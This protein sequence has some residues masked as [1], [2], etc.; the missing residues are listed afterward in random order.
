MF[1]GQTKALQF[2]KLSG[3]LD[4]RKGAS[5]A[6][7]YV[8]KI[9]DE[10]V[11][12]FKNK[13]PNNQKFNTAYNNIERGMLAFM[14]RTISGEEKIEFKRRKT[15]IEQSIEKL[16]ERGGV[17]GEKSKLYK[18]VYDKIL[19]DSNTI[20]EVQ[21]KVDKIN[22][23][24]VDWMTNIWSKNYD[25]LSRVNKN[26]YNKIL[27]KDINYTPD[28]FIRLDKVS[29]VNEI[30]EP[31]F[32][33]ALKRISDKKSGVLME[34][35]RPKSLPETRVINLNFDS[36]NLSSLEKA[37]TD[38]ETAGSIQQLKGFFESENFKKIVPNAQ[39]RQ[40]LKDR[41]V[42]LYNPIF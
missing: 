8:N 17:D 39:D 19:K 40:I 28:S 42:Q 14:R 18:E 26:I 32:D 30:G 3:F 2:E 35:L 29:D 9:T 24:A 36:Q 12:I 11:K 27:G 41:G 31:I 34:V 37:K 21:S 15:L 10:Y 13:K 22:L 4:L 23:Q 7:N 5:V 16:S 33:F 25:A 20:G 6:K 38:V 1:K